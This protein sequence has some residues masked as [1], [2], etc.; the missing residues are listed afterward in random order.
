M[1]L[2]DN[3]DC[4]ENLDKKV[5]AS[6]DTLQAPAGSNMSDTTLFTLQVMLASKVR[7]V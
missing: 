3:Q 5:T 7:K 6:S 4:L 2:L 1:V